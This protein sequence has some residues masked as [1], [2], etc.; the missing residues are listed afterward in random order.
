MK[1]VRVHRVNCSGWHEMPRQKQFYPKDTH[2]FISEDLGILL[3]SGSDMKSSENRIRKGCRF[4]I[5]IPLGEFDINFLDKHLMNLSQ[6]LQ[7]PIKS[8][9]R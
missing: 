4:E 1:Y 3:Y 7:I 2:N 9:S 8:W 5:R 6:Y